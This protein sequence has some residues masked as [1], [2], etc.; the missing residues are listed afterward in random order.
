VRL[1][2]SLDPWTKEVG[3]MRRLE[4]TLVLLPLLL[5]ACGGGEELN[6]DRSA[7]AVRVLPSPPSSPPQDESYLFYLHGR[8]VEAQGARPEHPQFGFYEYRS[9]LN[10]LADGGPVVISEQRR[11]GTDIREYATRISAQVERLL[12]AGVPPERITVTGFSKGGLIAAWVSAELGVPAINY[13]LMA[14]CGPWMQ[15]AEDFRLS[16][17]VLSLR[18]E[19]DARA[20][21]CLAA[22]EAAELPE[23]EELMLSIGGGHG[24]FY[25]PRP[26]WIEPLIQWSRGEAVTP[27][28]A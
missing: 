9:I 11:G 1:D 24:A 22:F 10:E 6:Y 21:S 19:S 18:E 25:R 5:L 13:V 8:I 3:T 17:R 15:Q 2:L 16:G 7:L 27:S 14:S 20:G 4:A 23:S 28:P 26:E 12:D